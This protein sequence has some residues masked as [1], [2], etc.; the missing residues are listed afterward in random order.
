MEF[1]F[2]YEEPR[3]V[4]K[5]LMTQ[6][7][8]CLANRQNLIAH[9]PTGLGKT[10]AFIAPALSYA[11]K[12]DLT[13]FFLT[14]K[15]SQHYI[16]V[17]TLKQIR[18]KFNLDF[19]IVDFI[20]KK[21]MCLQ[22]GV[23]VLPNGEFHDYCRELRKKDNCGFYLNLKNK[24]TRDLVLSEVNK[25]LHVEEVNK[26][27]RNYGIC[28][29]EIAGIM[30]KNSKVIIADYFHILSP[31]IR[32][33]LFKR[34]QKDLSKCIVY[35][36]EAHNLPD[37]CRDLLTINL[38]TLT[39]DR[40]MKENKDFG[41]DYEDDL[42][43]IYNIFNRLGRNIPLDKNDVLVMRGDLDFDKSIIEPMMEAAELVREERKKSAL[44][45][46]ANFLSSWLGPDESFVRIV[47]RG[48]SFQGKPFFKL[49]YRCLDPSILISQL[50]VHSLIFMSGTLYPVHMY[51]DLFGID[52]NNTVTTEYNNPFLDENKLNLIVPTTT[53][54]FTKR[55]GE[56]Y[57]R[58]SKICS[59]I[60]NV[61]PGNSAIFFPSYELR[62]QVYYFFQHDCDKTLILEQSGLNKKDKQELID[63][64][65]AYSKEGAVLLG[66]AAGSFGEGIDLPGDL[67]KTVI[68]VGLPLA[69]PDI[70]TRELINYYDKRFARGWD[71][72]Y[73]YPAIV[74]SLQNAGRCIRSEEDKGC[75]IFLDERYLWENYKRCFPSDSNFEIT[76]I[77]QER[78][79][80][81]FK[82]I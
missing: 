78:V 48:F 70:E 46:V 11:L 8:S 75:V 23:E 36:D 58:I 67:L 51:L 16:A 41:F 47:S 5:A 43:N 81:F 71:Y 18:E 45:T 39:L 12:N 4:Q 54:K 32:D 19:Q 82:K 69:K 22:S 59:E 17:E 77:P 79:R 52:K 80:E 26:V 37:K 74:K 68:V 6:I 49:T 10:A 57:K 53:T 76:K 50:N 64:F 61:T 14:P 13:L 73:V 40:A 55:S 62:N 9:A 20:G 33:S 60:V 42:F 66:A 72:A 1:Y 65:K 63:K 38:S 27:C 2:P 15:H 35:F 21:H 7:S 28:P 29:Y 3:K 24:T 34:I 25:P 56:M 44:G 31:S 30:G